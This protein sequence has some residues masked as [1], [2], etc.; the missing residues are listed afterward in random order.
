MYFLLEIWGLPKVRS[1]YQNCAIVSFNRQT[2]PHQV[3]AWG[4][5]GII[6]EIFEAL[7]EGICDAAA[8]RVSFYLSEGC[9]PKAKWLCKR[10]IFLVGVNALLVSS[11]YL[12]IS[13][14]IAVGLTSDPTLQNLIVD[15]SGMLSLANLAMVFAQ[16]HWSLLGAQ[17]RYAVASLWLLLSRWFCAAPISAICVHIFDF[18]PKA[19]VG[20]ISLCY[21]TAS[22][23]LSISLW[24][25]DWEDLE[26]HTHGG[27]SLQAEDSGI[28][29]S[30]IDPNDDEASWR[31]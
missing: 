18:E 25:V 21:A 27:P 4:M 23:A 28:D 22:F 19:I 7:T 10:F 3:A 11:V 5:M 6:W 12:M 9:V 16:M 15:T 30:S 31:M 20:A 24:R 29:L 13:P 26:I 8:V 2:Y 14:N 17:N 1:H